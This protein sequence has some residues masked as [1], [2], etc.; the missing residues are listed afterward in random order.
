MKE[1]NKELYERI[2]IDI[3]KDTYLANETDDVR[4]YPIEKNIPLQ[5][6]PTTI[7][8]NVLT[9]YPII[10]K[11]EVGDSFLMTGCQY[12]I[13]YELAKIR[14]CLKETKSKI[15]LTKKT[16]PID[17]FKKLLKIFVTS[18]QTSPVLA[19]YSP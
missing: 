1:F 15:V 8:T 7:K 17:V 19:G 11:L 3:K 16:K 12:R 4:T 6:F 2:K 5:I 18:A 10:K 13:N 9:K 14:K